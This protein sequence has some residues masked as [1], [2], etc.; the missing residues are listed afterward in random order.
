MS[1]II[2]AVSVVLTYKDKI[3]AI[4]RQ[5]F[6]TAFPG[7]WAFP[8][9]KV[10]KDDADFFQ[11]V[12]Q[13]KGLDQKLFGAVVREIKEELGIDLNLE[14]SKGHVGACHYLGLAVT[15]DFNPF[16]FATYFFKIELNKQIP[17]TVDTN[18][19]RV[20]DW[21][22]AEK[23]L[24]KYEMGE[25]LA[26][27][28]VIKVIQ[29]LGKNPET[30]FI[31]DLN[32]SYDSTELVPYIESLKGIRQIMPLSHT[33]PPATRTNAFLIGDDGSPKILIDPSP[34]NEE[35]YRKFRNTLNLFGV[36]QIL[37]THHHPDH[38]ERSN[39]LARE[40]NLPVLLSEYTLKII[41]K[42]RP[43]YFLNVNTRVI[44]DGDVVTKWNQ[45][46]VL[47]MEVPG[48]DEGQVALYSKNLSWFLAGD[49]FQGIG[50]VV[51]GGEEGDMT[52]YFNTLSK[53]I[54]LAP[55][56]V[57][58]SHG[59]GLGGTTILEKT[60]N[61]RKEREAQVYSLYTEGLTPEEILPRLYGEVDKA[62]WPYALQNISKHLEKLRL[63]GRI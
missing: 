63:E 44:K 34:I 42:N 49:L 48:H 41:L 18:E 19:A 53:V 32:I 56:V 30:A 62:L 7:Y 20:F 37:I 55:K 8:G 51:I 57:F 61:H 5:N 38:Y 2:D 40:L 27:P 28:P 52:K 50:T 58:P 35:E 25:V 36:D 47:V 13:T 14:I 46:D 12:P 23:L 54:N 9:G 17:F 39:Q 10:E 26:V 60:L 31:G 15:P 11:D 21:M 24:N 1:K 16:R 4:Q 29:I 22:S 6:L 3:F 59:I 33:L 45:N 43:D